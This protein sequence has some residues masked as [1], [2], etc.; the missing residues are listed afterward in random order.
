VYLYLRHLENAKL[1]NFIAAEGK[2]V[3]TLQKPDKIY[4]E[5]TNISYA[6]RHNPDKGN[7]RETFLLNQL[8]NADLET[9][10]PKNGDFLVD[11][12]YI[13]EVGGKGK[14]AKQIKNT[15]ESYLAI[16]DIEVG[17]GNKIPLWLFGFLY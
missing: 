17:F 1:L 13:V 8:Q 7:L 9:T 5:N 12:R 6:L 3:S 10:L 2:G 11:G 14:T 4:L 15:T 16:D